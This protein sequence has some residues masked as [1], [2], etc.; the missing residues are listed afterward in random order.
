MEPLFKRVVIKQEKQPED[1]FAEVKLKAYVHKVS[2]DCDERVQ[3][4]VGKEVKY[5]AGDVID[6]D[7]EFNY[8]LLHE[9]SLLYFV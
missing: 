8:L 3:N 2:T 4:S 7:D 9:T 6:Q 1:V 5:T